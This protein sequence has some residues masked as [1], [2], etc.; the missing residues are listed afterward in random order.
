MG[1][2]IF[3]TLFGV[4]LAGLVA[5]NFLMVDTSKENS[6]PVTGVVIAVAEGPSNDILVQLDNHETMYYINRGIESG[7]EVESLSNELVGETITL[8]IGDQRLGT[9][10]HITHLDHGDVF[11]SEWQ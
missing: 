3:G 5:I 10:S 8:W 1:Y 6:T 7:L 4:L 11:Y 2:R 9:P